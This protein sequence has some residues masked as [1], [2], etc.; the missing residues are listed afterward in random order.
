MALNFLTLV[1]SV[2]LRFGGVKLN[3]STFAG[4]TDPE[5][6][7]VKDAVN[8]A[9]RTINSKFHEWPFNYVAGTITMV[10]GTGTYSKATAA[11]SVD[12]DTFLIDANSSLSVGEKH[13]PYI[14]YDKYITHY[15]E[16]D[17]DAGTSDYDVPDLVY[18]TPDNNIGVTPLPDNT[19]SLKYSYFAVPTTL[20][21]YNAETTIPEEYQNVVTDGASPA[22]SLKRGN[23][24][25]SNAYE[26]KFANGISNMRR[27]LINAPVDV[28]ST[29]RQR[30]NSGSRMLRVG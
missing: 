24:E 15:A 22:M 16:R 23:I 13:L 27:I 19:Y 7:L 3:S 8:D 25:Q 5:H 1:N 14:D 28:K 29:M 21:A 18:R 2:L 6:L 11:K 12:W 17:G 9:I 10:A 20:V 4:T 26:N 30:S